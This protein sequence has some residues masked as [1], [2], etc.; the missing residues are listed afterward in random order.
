MALTLTITAESAEDLRTQLHVLLG[1]SVI[2][3][4][5]AEALGRAGLARSDTAK[6]SVAAPVPSQRNPNVKT[7][8]TEG[9]PEEITEQKQDVKPRRAHRKVKTPANSEPSEPS[10]APEPSHNG[11]ALATQRGTTPVATSDVS[12]PDGDE[13]IFSG[14]DPVDAQKIKDEVLPQLRDLFVS[15]KVKQVRAILDKFGDGAKSIPEIDARQFPA[16]RDF[17]TQGSAA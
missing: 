5:L 15:G 10:G 7:I 11:E 12:H 8:S 14:F 4:A 9:P 13:D 16:I 1:A 17:L 2:S 3:A 6:P